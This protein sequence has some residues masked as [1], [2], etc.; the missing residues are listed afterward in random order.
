MTKWIFLVSGV[1][2]LSGYKYIYKLEFQGRGVLACWKTSQ[3]H[4]SPTP[5]QQTV[6]IFTSRT[7][8]FFLKDFMSFFFFN[9]KDFSLPCSYCE[10]AY[11]L[12]VCVCISLRGGG[13]SCAGVFM[14]LNV[15]LLI[16][17]SSDERQ[18]TNRWCSYPS[19]FAG[20]ES[21]SQ[22]KF[23]FKQ[24]VFWSLNHFA[25]RQCSFQFQILAVG[26]AEGV[27]DFATGQCFLLLFPGVTDRRDATNKLIEIRISNEGT[28]LKYKIY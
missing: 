22:E 19:L 4:Y 18:S 27:A 17:L 10:C 6:F 13:E 26:Q 23:S 5:S 25:F 2:C 8:I 12:C 7:F 3:M 28:F 20:G 11:L 16:N 15:Y 21:E 1:L 24:E 14:L 9:T